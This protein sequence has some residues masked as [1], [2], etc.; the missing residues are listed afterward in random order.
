MDGASVLVVVD[1]F[2]RRDLSLLVDYLAYCIC[3]VSVIILYT[4]ICT[5]PPSGKRVAH[6]TIII[7]QENFVHMAK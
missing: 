7:F 3:I 1:A 4:K 5:F 6:I 2:A